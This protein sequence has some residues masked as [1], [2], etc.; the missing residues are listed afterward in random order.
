MSY[1]KPGYVPCYTENIP[2]VW[3][4]VPHSTCQVFIICFWF[5]P[6]SANWYK[7]HYVKHFSWVVKACIPKVPFLGLRKHVILLRSADFF[8]KHKFHGHS[9]R[10]TAV[11]GEGVMFFSWCLSQC[12]IIYS[13]VRNLDSKFFK[14]EHC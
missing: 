5:T 10:R 3:R 12:Q 13:E 14:S 1:S 2:T 11:R 9:F 4:T 6:L 8:C 7:R